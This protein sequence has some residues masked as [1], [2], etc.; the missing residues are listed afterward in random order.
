MK[1]KLEEDP[2]NKQQR[3]QEMFKRIE[4]VLETFIDAGVSDYMNRHEGRTTTSGVAERLAETMPTYVYDQE[5]SS[6]FRRGP[7]MNT[8]SRS[9]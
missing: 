5:Y 2:G 6:I 7:T 8:S 3:Q 1:R 4:H 9:I